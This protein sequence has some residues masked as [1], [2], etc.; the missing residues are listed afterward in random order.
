VSKYSGLCAIR[1]IK[2]LSPKIFSL[3]IECFSIAR[4]GKPG[5]FVQIKL[6]DYP[7][8]IWPRPFSI[9]KINGDTL[10]LSIKKFGKITKILEARK[11]GDK[12][13][14]TGPLGN[15]FTDPSPGNDI[16][17]VAGG[18]GLPPLHF[19]CSKLIES[20]YP[21]ERIHFYSGSK[22]A[23]EL[24]GHDE[25]KLLGIDYVTATDD[26]SFGIKGYVTE[27]LAVELTRRRTGD[28]EFKP[29]IYGC[30]PMAMLKRLAEICHGL[31]CYLSLEQLMPC[32]WGVCN[33]CAIKLKP[34]DNIISEDKR[35]Y[36]LARVCKD[37]PIFEASEVIWE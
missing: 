22:T 13:F 35:D 9:H 31:P 24:F 26:G 28:A 10:T 8:A 21:K 30:G 12:L 16:Y 2:I 20:G 37:G 5:Q 17:F 33:G 14:I 23:D 6:V 29:I 18:V 36:R 15:S 4:A 11:P 32:G 1:E 27:P 3:T 34:H 19:F 25:L 7:S